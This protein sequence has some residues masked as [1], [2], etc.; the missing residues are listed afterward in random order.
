MIYFEL[1]Q[2][3]SLTARYVMWFAWAN[4]GFA[5]V[6]KGIIQLEPL[7]L[8]DCHGKQIPNFI[9]YGIPK[10]VT[11]LDLSRNLIPNLKENSFAQLHQLKYL[12]LD[13][14]YLINPIKFLIPW[15][16]GWFSPEMTIFWLWNWMKMIHAPFVSLPF[17]IGSSS[18]WLPF[19]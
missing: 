17:Y 10:E 16:S 7:H 14:E 4:P 11:A 8:V 18:F 2:V 19:G 3:M 13:G 5:W 6:H 15:D 9:P 12:N 1:S